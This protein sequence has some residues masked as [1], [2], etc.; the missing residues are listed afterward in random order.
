[1]K[2]LKEKSREYNGNS[3]FKYKI[4]IPQGVLERAQIKQ[5]E[6]V[7]ATSEIG[8]ILLSKKNK[9]KQEFDGIRARL[10][11]ECLQDFPNAREQDIKIMKKYFSPKS[12]ERVL[13]VGAGSGLFSNHI[14]EI[15]GK[16]GRLIVSDPSLDQLEEIKKLKKKNID[17]IQ[18]VQFGSENVDLEKE[19]VDGI[20]SFGAFH[21]VKQK[22]KAFENYARVL[23]KDGRLVIADVFQGSKLAKHFDNMVAKYC[24][25]GHEVSFLSR[26]FADSLCFL[27]K[28]EKPIFYDLNIQ[29]KFKEKKEIGEFLYK[30]H[31][32]TRTSQENCLKGAEEILGIK[33]KGDFY[34][35]NWPMTIL[36]TKLIS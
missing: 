2:I 20:W 8:E 29:W 17:T 16:K 9:K 12:G 4:N 28:F 1:M 33:R 11:K 32:M 31:A 10:Y 13:E 3:Y 18:F 7:Q 35:L 6:E 5:G 25:T 21:H 30:L 36:I 34:Y 22:V 14:A 19:K 26:E 15:I 27:C 24:I 23:K